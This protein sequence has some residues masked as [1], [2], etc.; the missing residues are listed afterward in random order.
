MKSLMATAEVK[1]ILQE[2]EEQSE[3]QL[4]RSSKKQPRLARWIKDCAEVYSPP[5][6]TEVASRMRMKS[7]WA[8]DLTTLDE[9]GNPWDFSLPRQRKKALELLKKDKP[10]FLVACPMCGPFSS[11]NDLNYGKMS[12]E[13]IRKKLQDAMM[14]M[15][16]ALSL[17]LVQ[18]AEGRMFMFEHPAGASSW[19]TKMMQEM[20]SKE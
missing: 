16:F 15:R 18:V 7:A 12:E 17:C 2:I 6:V 4:P 1:R 10:L 3:L 13:E 8:L 11:I 9:E 5:R 14:H 20:L 19:G